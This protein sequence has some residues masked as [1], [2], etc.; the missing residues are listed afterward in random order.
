MCSRW[1]AGEGAPVE[2]C[3]VRTAVQRLWR[4]LCTLARGDMAN[5]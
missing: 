2:G 4:E 5:E 1:M 3:L